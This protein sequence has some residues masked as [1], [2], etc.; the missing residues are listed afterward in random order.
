MPGSAETVGYPMENL[1]MMT[2]VKI[3]GLRRGAQ[4]HAER[5]GQEQ[6][7]ALVLREAQRRTCL[8]SVC[9]VEITSPGARS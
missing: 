7:P 9:V 3:V 4:L 2:E 5:A 8:L 1:A 6:H